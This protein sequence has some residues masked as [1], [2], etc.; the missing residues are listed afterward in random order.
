MALGI[1]QVGLAMLLR[2]SMTRWLARA[3][4]WKAVVVVNSSI[5]TLFLW[6]ISALVMTIAILIQVGFPQADFG[7]GFWWLLRPLWFG[8]ATLILAGLVWVFGRFERP[9][10]DPAERYW[11]LKEFYAL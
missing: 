11:D 3:W 2:P 6:H 9:D 5:M 7:S 1:G 10:L 8:L 4:P